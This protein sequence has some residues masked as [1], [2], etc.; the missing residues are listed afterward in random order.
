MSPQ[1]LKIALMREI[2]V[3]YDG[4]KYQKVS[5]I[6][7]RKGERGIMLQAELWDK[8]SVT[9][10]SPLKTKLAEPI[11]VDTIKQVTKLEKAIAYFKEYAELTEDILSQKSQHSFYAM[12]YKALL[13]EQSNTMFEYENK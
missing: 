2:P 3:I 6:I 12:A 7:Y 9:I 4:I 1:D 10:A 11:K 13:K 8:H 5:G